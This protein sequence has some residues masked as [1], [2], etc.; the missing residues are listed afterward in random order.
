MVRR[1]PGGIVR[2]MR[3]SGQTI[4]EWLAV[5]AGV[6]ALWPRAAP[7][8]VPSVAP[9]VTGGMQTEICH[10]T[11]GSCAGRATP[12]PSR[13]AR[14]RRRADAARRPRRRDL[15]G[16]SSSTPPSCGSQ[17][18]REPRPLLR[19]APRQGRLR[20]RLPHDMLAICAT[21]S[22]SSG[23]VSPSHARL[24]PRRRAPLLQGVSSEAGSPTATARCAARSRPRHTARARARGA[25]SCPRASW[26]SP[27]R[28]APRGCACR[29][30]RAPPP[31]P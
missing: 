11:G 12:P 20:H 13:R 14:P 29:A 19:R 27:R 17:R 9:A 1:G 4:V 6:V 21:G 8:A 23:G 16:S 2:G 5:L 30:R 22:S 26:G 24:V 3:E 25:G 31:R 10:V 7:V 15:C 28:S 18:V